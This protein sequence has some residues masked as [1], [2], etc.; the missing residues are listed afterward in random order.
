MAHVERVA[1][2][3]SRHLGCL[4]FLPSGPQAHRLLDYSRGMSHTAFWSSGP[5]TVVLT[6]FLSSCLSGSVQLEMMLM[7][8][9]DI[10]EANYGANVQVMPLSLAHVSRS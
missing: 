3:L 7:I 10:P 8:R 1:S 6:H 2:S 9:A 4:R 5:R